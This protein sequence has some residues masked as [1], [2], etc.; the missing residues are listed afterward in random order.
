MKDR[1]KK[2]LKGYL[3]LTSL[4]AWWTRVEREEKQFFKLVEQERIE[5]KRKEDK[6]A[7]K[8]NEKENFV[9]KFFPDS[10]SSPWWNF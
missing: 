7:E 6:N 2:K 8:R 3:C 1:K 5:R 9:R 4:P 10:N